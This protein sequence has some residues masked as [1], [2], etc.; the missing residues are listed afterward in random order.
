[1]VITHLK[2]FAACLCLRLY[3][4]PSLQTI[5]ATLALELASYADVLRLVTHLAS[6]RTSAREATLEQKREIFRAAK[7]SLISITGELVK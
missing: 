4:K 5:W 2:C 7:L 3:R 1:M 6:L